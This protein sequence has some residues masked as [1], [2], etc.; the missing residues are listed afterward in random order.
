MKITLRKRPISR[1]AKYSLILDFSPPLKH[2][3]KNK[4]IR[5]HTLGVY[6]Y[7]KPKNLLQRKENRETELLSKIRTSG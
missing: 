5:F 7:N 3:E 6:L 2:L 4:R 1:G